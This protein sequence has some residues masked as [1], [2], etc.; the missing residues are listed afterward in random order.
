VLLDAART[1]ISQNP[2]SGQF[3]S[4][5][6]YV[7]NVPGA[8]GTSTCSALCGL[9][10][11]PAFSYDCASRGIQTMRHRSIEQPPTKED[12]VRIVQRRATAGDKR[13]FRQ[14]LRRMRKAFFLNTKNQPLSTRERLVEQYRKD[15]LV[16]FL[17]AGVSSDSG[18]PSWPDLTKALLELCVEDGEREDVKK[19]LPSYITQFELAG[20]HLGY[21]KLVKAIHQE[22]YDGMKCGPVKKVPLSF[23]RQK[24]WKQWKAVLRA[25]QDNKTLEAVGNFLIIYDGKKPRRNPQIHA[26]LTFNADNLLELYCT[27][28]SSGRRVLTLVDRASV[29][30]HPNETPVY[31]LHGSLDA[32]GEN[33]FR[34][35]PASVPPN[36]EQKL[37]DDLLPDLIFRESEYYET[38]ANP[39]S[40][41]NHTPQSV[42]R[43]LNAL[44][45]GT[46]LDDL[47]MRRWLHDSFRERVQHRTKYLREFYWRKYGDAK[48]EAELESCRH[49]WLRCETDEDKDKNGGTRRVPKEH[50]CRVMSNLGVQVI[51]CKDF[52]DIRKCIREVQKQG[53]DSKFGRHPADYPS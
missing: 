1:P 47:N 38:I 2:V 18:I 26:V 35:R 6:P 24:K 48:Y 33:I 27:A 40:F 52:D 5:R 12:I 37:T 11:L 30:E 10:G 32:R 41:V 44:F 3:P 17:G 46:S 43:R 20:R 16:L 28:K 39:V 23:K 7:Q 31:H 9:G 34:K 15:G 14:F 19:A 29:G 13:R 4:S 8:N 42:L 50:V 51:W 49:F 53:H 22:L 36:K 25:L 21:R 45:I